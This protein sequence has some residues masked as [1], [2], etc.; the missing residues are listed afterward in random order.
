MYVIYQCNQEACH[1]LFLQ[2]PTSVANRHTFWPNWE[3]CTLNEELRLAREAAAHAIF[4]SK[5]FKVDLQGG[6]KIALHD[7]L[8][9]APLSPFY[10]NLR[11]TGVK[12]GTL[13]QRDIWAISKAMYHLG[14]EEGCLAPGR[15]V[16]SI[17]AAGDPYLDAI[18]DEVALDRSGMRMP[19]R[20]Y[21]EKL[22]VNG[23]RAFALSPSDA[24]TWS[25]A[26]L[27]DDLVTSMLTKLLAVKSIEQ[28]NGHVSDLLVFL[29][30]SS[31]A[32]KKLAGLG[33]TLHAVWDFEHFMEWA[34]GQ[35]Y[36]NRRQYE[37]ITQYPD[38][39]AA[40]KKSV[41]YVN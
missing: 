41:N 29:N 37:S 16:C 32:K 12:G 3:D 34:L 17:P 4:K 40:Y 35:G 2:Y 14:L 9:D 33:I 19:Q 10:L 38:T 31:D 24:F 8:P 18:M 36:L 39:L 7:E 30:R 21:L 26:V 27:F 5:S 1:F 11:R 15:A 25:N 28:C 6:F 13:E 20:F 22:E 23:K